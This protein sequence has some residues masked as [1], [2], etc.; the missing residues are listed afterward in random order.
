VSTL[1]SIRISLLYQVSTDL[2]MELNL[3]DQFRTTKIPLF[4]MVERGI[5]V[6]SELRV[7]AYLRIIGAFGGSSGAQMR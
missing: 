5:L 7:S 2:W 6:A 3:G 4:D 1:P